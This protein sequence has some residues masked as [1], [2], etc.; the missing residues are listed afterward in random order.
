MIVDA[1]GGTIDIS[2]YSRDQKGDFEEIAAP[3]CSFVSVTL[4]VVNFR[5]VY[6]RSL[7][8]LCF[9]DPQCK[10]VYKEYVLIA[11]L[12]LLYHQSTSLPRSLGRLTLS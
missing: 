4:K 6:A 10:T 11:R 5:S 3:Q 9:C 12:A 1:G 8:R 7:P 2:S